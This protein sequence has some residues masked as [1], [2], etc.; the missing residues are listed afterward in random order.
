MVEEVVKRLNRLPSRQL[1]LLRS[2]IVFSIVVIASIVF[3]IDTFFSHHLW[4]DDITQKDYGTSIVSPRSYLYFAAH[5]WSLRELPPPVV[6]LIYVSI[7]GA[8]A[9]IGAGLLRRVLVRPWDAE[10]VAVVGFLCPSTL[11]TF[12]FIN[13]S[14]NVLFLFF[15]VLLIKILINIY[16]RETISK[17]LIIFN[18]FFLG[19]VFLS[20]GTTTNGVLLLPALIL[21]PWWNSPMRKNGKIFLVQVFF[22]A[23]TLSTLTF[24]AIYD[25]N[26]SHPYVK[27]DDRI[28]HDPFEILENIYRVISLS[29]R[30][31]IEPI[32]STG[33]NI[34]SLETGGLL[35]VIIFLLFA[36]TLYTHFVK[37][38]AGYI[39]STP[40]AIEWSA[41]PHLTLFIS[42]LIIF[43]VFGIATN[44]KIHLWHFFLP[45]IFISILI[46][47]FVVLYFSRPVLIVISL[48]LLVASAGSFQKQNSRF[49]IDVILMDSLEG[50]FSEHNSEWQT[51]TDLFVITELPPNAGI[52]TGSRSLSFLN[53]YQSTHNVSSIFFGSELSVSSEISK[54]ETTLGTDT[55]VYE[56]NDLNN[57]WTET[58]SNWQTVTLDDPNS[59]RRFFCTETDEKK[60]LPGFLE[61]D[62]IFNEFTLE[63][64]K[65]VKSGS[66]IS[67][68][69][70]V[71]VESVYFLSIEIEANDGSF[72]EENNSYTEITPPMPFLGPSVGAYQT[73]RGYV[74][75]ER[76]T[77]SLIFAADGTGKIWL[78]IIGC[79][80]GRVFASLND[81][82]LTEVPIAGVNGEWR[83][84]SG[85]KDRIWMGD[86]SFELFTLE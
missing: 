69:V 10:I 5:L 74:L 17:S 6:R 47:T 70:D 59:L 61:D 1:V 76:S 66:P 64:E 8:T 52:A 45:G 9:S 3:R 43:S 49:Y 23:F 24:Y 67:L 20:V 62:E 33:Q 39:K 80:G 28:T 2:L 46:A 11:V 86:L 35:V 54:K 63:I 15:Y 22:S 34:K 71:P 60:G 82:P 25:L 78:D 68:T 56:R 83:L 40:R 13:G 41:V 65:E 12:I 38:I 84:G 42:A 75:R 58:S 31:Y 26:A 72:V 81:N 32:L 48:I 44:R 14:Y 55:R 21:L 19:V 36:G 29:L 37:A 79:E 16:S 7:F 53:H 30:M 18:V 57:G 73:A 27:F 4:L 85:W 50:L 51:D 77:S